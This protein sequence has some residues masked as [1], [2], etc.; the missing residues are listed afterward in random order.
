MSQ[1]LLTDK[2]K[3]DIVADAVANAHTRSNTEIGRPYGV[4]DERVRLILSEA[5]IT[6]ARKLGT[7][8]TCK[9]DGCTRTFRGTK[10]YS[11]HKA[12]YCEQ[13]RGKS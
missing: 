3:A 11:G 10:T 13:H 8:H 6:K 12:R 5:G 7:L 4:S 2:Q 1:V 9:H